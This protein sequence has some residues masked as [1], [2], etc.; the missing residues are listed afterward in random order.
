VFVQISQDIRLFYEAYGD[1]NNPA[2][3][4]LHGLGADHRMWQPQLAHYPQAGFFVIAPDLRGHGSSSIPETFT[5]QDCAHDMYELLN[6]LRV[7]QAHV[8]GVSMGGMVGQQLAIEYPDCIATMTIVD[9]LSGATRPVERFNGWLA[10]VLL[11]VFPPK[12]QASLIKS[13]YSKMGKADVGAYFEECLSRMDNAWI[14][15][16]R[17]RVNAFNVCERLSEIQTPTLVLVGD[18]FGA[19]AIDMARTTAE[20]IGTADFQVLPGGGD[21]S[22]LIVPD[23]FDSA[24]LEFVKSVDAQ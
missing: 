11:A 4:L 18:R 21:P 22:N 13:T 12:L 24:V 17:Q 10:A 20:G 1:K 16:M 15:H 19:L 14:R 8:I 6:A 3:L 2:M 5:I 9:S 23:A 7:D